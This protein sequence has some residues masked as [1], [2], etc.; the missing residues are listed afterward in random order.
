MPITPQPST[1]RTLNHEPEAITYARLNAGLTKAQ[2]AEKLGKS[3]QLVGEIESGR[4]NATP[5][6]L[7]KLA[8]IFNCPVVVLQ[9]KRWVA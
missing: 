3:P 1:P 5:D 8:E 7:K 4:R 6:T 2:V 9:R